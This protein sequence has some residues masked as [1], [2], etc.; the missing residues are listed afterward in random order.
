MKTKTKVLFT[1]ILAIF[2]IACITLIIACLDPIKWSYEHVYSGLDWCN[3]IFYPTLFSAIFF[4]IFFIFN[5]FLIFF[6]WK[7]DIDFLTEQEKE[8]RKRAKIEKMQKEIER[9]KDGE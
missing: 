8:K 7:K 9:L 2:S 5:I 3:M 6:F 4:G 1:V